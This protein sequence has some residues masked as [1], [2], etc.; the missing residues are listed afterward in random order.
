MS[1]PLMGGMGR[2]S[3]NA[4]VKDIIRPTLPIRVNPIAKIIPKMTAKAKPMNTDIA[5]TMPSER[6]VKLLE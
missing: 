1:L 2:A 4:I 6:L 3:K 5:A